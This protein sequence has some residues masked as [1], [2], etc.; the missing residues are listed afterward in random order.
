MRRL[1][2]GVVGIGIGAVVG[3]SIVRWAGK[4]KQRYSPP[5]LAREAGGVA[6][7]F[8]SRVRDALDAGREEMTR[9]EMEIRAELGLPVQ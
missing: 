4:T 5:N 7:D 8:A 3:V 6:S 9:A 2:W 1:F